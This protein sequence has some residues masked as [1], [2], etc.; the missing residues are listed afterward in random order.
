[1]RLEDD[2]VRVEARSMIISAQIVLL[3]RFTVLDRLMLAL[4]F[5][6]L[7]LSLVAVDAGPLERVVGIFL[8]HLGLKL[9]LLADEDYLML[10]IRVTFHTINILNFMPHVDEPRVFLVAADLDQLGWVSTLLLAGSKVELALQTAQ[11]TLALLLF[12]TEVDVLA[13]QVLVHHDLLFCAR[14]V[15]VFTHGVAKGLLVREEAKLVAT[16]LRSF[17]HNGDRC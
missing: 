14:V 7:L 2:L 11:V 15:Q 5:L 6:F 4:P 1:M 17:D 9:L 3:E 10:L 13:L 8:M 12:L 16:L